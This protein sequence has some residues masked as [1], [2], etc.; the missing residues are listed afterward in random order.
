MMRCRCVPKTLWEGKIP[1]MARAAFLTD[2]VGGLF[3]ELLCTICTSSDFSILV[4]FSMKILAILN[5][6]VLQTFAVSPSVLQ[7]AD[8][9][10]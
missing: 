3:G 7:Y 4:V 1:S 8:F 10:F 9:Y 5:S 6:K 2:F